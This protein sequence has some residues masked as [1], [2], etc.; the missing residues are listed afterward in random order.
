MKAWQVFQH[1][2]PEEALHLVDAPV[3]DPGPADVR[4]RVGAATLALPDVMMCRGV[5]PL[6]PP[7]PFTSG[8]EVAGVVTAAGPESP[9]GV[10]QRVMTVTAFVRGFGG[11]AEECIAPGG[12][13]FPV[14]ESMPD[15]DAAAFLIAYHTGW[16]GLVRRGQLAWG[17]TLVVTGAA[18]GTGAAAIQL[19]KA[20]GA[21]VIAVAGG[22]AK[23]EICRKLGADEV[24]DHH[25]TDVVEAVRAATGGRGA[26]VVYE[27]V[28]GQVF[29][30]ACRYVASEGRILTVGFASGDW[31]SLTTEPI[32][33][34]NWSVVG[35]FAGAYNHN[36]WLPDHDA[37]L[38]LYD[39]GKLPPLVETIPFDSL[40]AGLTKVAGREAVGRLVLLPA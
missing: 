12:A 34:G 31:G 32:T 8:Q 5:Y 30:D 4:I 20:L 6:T 16:I 19:G 38:R 28:G 15:V 37:M 29:A 11:F 10:G 25:T 21:T 1:G 36:D 17:E 27:P 7:L 13:T 24:I 14:P 33:R 35:V 39:E 18:G 23:G 40:P 2:E 22:D 9:V 26:D 3:P